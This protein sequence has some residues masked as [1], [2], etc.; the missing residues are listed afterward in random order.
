MLKKIRF[1]QN[2]EPLLAISPINFVLVFFKVDAISYA[3]LKGIT[4]THSI[5]VNANQI[6]SRELDTVSSLFHRGRM[7]LNSPGSSFK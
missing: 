3:L 7:Q 4:L 6:H 2:T 1:L 5:N